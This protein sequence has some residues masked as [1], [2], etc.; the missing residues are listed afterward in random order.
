MLSALD[1]V[2][3]IGS[4]ALAAL[5]AV[6]LF[7]GPAV[8]AEDEGDPAKPAAA[9]ASPYARGGGADTDA[10]ALF[11]ENCGACHTLG[12]AGTTGTTGPSL[13]GG[14][15]ASAVEDAMVAG[16]GIMP[17]FG[18]ELSAADRKAIAEFVAGAD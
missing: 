3:A 17:E 14:L 2:V 18:N 1:K 15:P 7:A 6:M 5:L 16:P 9:G 4:W 11:T 13:D 12:A 10:K 8:V